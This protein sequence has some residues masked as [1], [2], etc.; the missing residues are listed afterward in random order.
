MRKKF[1]A[2]LIAVIMLTLTACGAEANPTVQNL[3]TNNAEAYNT[4]MLVADK[5]AV[6]PG[7]D[8]EYDI[9]FIMEFDMSFDGESMVMSTAGNL[10]MIV[11]GDN[12]KASMSMDMS[13][14]GLGSM[15]MYIDGDHVYALLDGEAF[16]MQMDDMMNQMDNS[17]STP[18]FDVDAITT[19]EIIERD[20]D[21]V[22][23]LTLDGQVMTD[24]VLANMED[25]LMNLG[26]I[27]MEM[28][29]DDIIIEIVGADVDNPKSMIMKMFMEMTVDGETISLGMNVIYIINKFGS[30]VV[31]NMPI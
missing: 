15:E 20:G 19:S 21:I 24:Y 10:K 12:V 8:G 17:I 11:E 22:T 23:I 31:I 7:A 2:T 4:Y 1:L 9:D 28:H 18:D 27:A 14:Y 6:G 25:A 16:E 3:S 5:L 29:I 26:D 30:G 13:E